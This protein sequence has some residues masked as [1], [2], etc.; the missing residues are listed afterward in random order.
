MASEYLK[1]KYRD[2]KP[3]E[4]IRYTPAEKRRNWWHYHKWH[5]AIGL[6]LALA[7]G[8]ILYHVLGVGQ[9]RPDYQ[10]AYVGADP[11]P[12]GTAAALETALAELGRDCNGDGRVVVRLN[13]YVSGANAQDGDSLYYATAASTLLMADLTACDSYFFLL[14]D[15]DAF[16]ENHQILRRL[17]GSLPADSDRDYASCYLPWTD[18]PALTGLDLGTYSEDLLGQE[19]SGN[20]QELLSGLYLARRG[21]WTE[22]TADY[23]DDCDALWA[24][25]TKGAF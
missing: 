4:P 13:Q 2:V 12:D 24:E 10:I 7:A 17:D 19:V 9:V 11:L 3:D 22:N 5:V 8:N 1:W 25:L 16:Q 23:A 14:D 6:V 18:C 20:S 15:P 21:F